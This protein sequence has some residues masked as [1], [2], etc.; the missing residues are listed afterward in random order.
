[1]FLFRSTAFAFRLSTAFFALCLLTGSSRAQNGSQGSINVT[2]LDSTGAVVSGADLQ[3][4]D[5]T[6]NDT[7]NA[8][9]GDRGG[10]TFVN[11]PI[12][13]YALTVSKSGF[14]TTSL[15]AVRASAAQ[16]TDLTEIGRASCRERV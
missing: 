1:M 10:Y 4:K 14:D 7:R 16:V 5:A 2:V 6:T 8:V 3:L 11:L 13:V 12:G 9:T 15:E